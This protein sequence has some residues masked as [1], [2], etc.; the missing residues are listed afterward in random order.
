MVVDADVTRAF[1][2]GRVPTNTTYITPEYLNEN[3]DPPARIAIIVIAAIVTVSL[4]LRCFSRIFLVKSFGLD[5]GLALFSYACFLAFVTLCIILIDQGSGR[6]IEYIQYVLSQATTNSTEIN[7]YAAHLIYTA[8]LFICRLSGLAFFYRLCSRHQP[9]QRVIRLAAVFLVCAFLPQFLLILLHCMPV[10]GLWPYAWQPE[11]GD[12]K[13]V[14]WVSLTVLAVDMIVRANQRQGTV[15]VTNS[16]LSLVCD[17]VVFSIPAAMITLLKLS[18]GRKVML[19]LLLMPGVAVIGISVA[20]LYLC[21]VGQWASDGS[22]V[23][24]T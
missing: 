12:Y 3:R 9:L 13:C 2:E 7:D 16:G 11:A 6:H 22:W 23:S 8:A 19:A 15:Y 17:L 24:R 5:D 1:A 14:T 20:R 10:T 21:V 18:H 4:G